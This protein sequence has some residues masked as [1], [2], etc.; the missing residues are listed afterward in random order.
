MARI[1]HVDDKEFWRELVKRRLRDHHVDSAGSLNEAIELLN[2]ESAYSLALVD[3]NLATDS[4]GQGRELL[5]LLR[6]RYPSTSRIV[7]T[8]SPPGGGLR[9][10]IFDAYDVEEIIIK[11]DFDIPGLRRVVEEAID[12]GGPTPPQQL[13]LNRSF[14]RQ[15]FRDWQRMQRTRLTEKRRAAEE[16]LYDAA[17]VSAQ[18]RE[19][20]QTDV[21]EAKKALKQ[22]NELCIRLRTMLGSI[23]TE[24]DLNAALEAL[25]AAEE[26][27]GEGPDEDGQ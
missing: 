22:F 14:L 10:N 20:A 26:Q 18:S 25:D 13:R 17:K 24:Q 2:S 1:L 16:H 4:D 15:R 19:R 21:D 11:S 9:K 23:R 8:A 6:M 7:L 3:L 12:Q 5:D 27:F